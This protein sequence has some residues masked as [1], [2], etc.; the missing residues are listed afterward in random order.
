MVFHPDP[1]SAVSSTISATI[2]ILEVTYQLKAVGQQTADLLS[3]TRH[4]DFMLQQANRLR[5]LKAGL[6]NTSERTMVDTVISDTEDALRAVA[7]LV[8]HCR[9]D[10][11]TTN[12]IKFGHRVMW[13]FRD[14]PSVRDKHQKLQVCYQSLT[15]V[16]N[17]L[18]S[19]DVVVIAPIPEVRSEEQPP[20]YDPQLKELLEW[21][22][23]RKGR[24]SKEERESI[25]NENLEVTNGNANPT[26]VAGASSPC[27]LA[28]D[29]CDNSRTSSLSTYTDMFSESPATTIS[30]ARPS[31]LP[32]S[33]NPLSPATQSPDST[34]PSLHTSAHSSFYGD[35][36]QST[37]PS[38]HART[39]NDCFGSMHNLPKIDSPPFAA[40][41]APYQF[42][43][44]DKDGLQVGHK[45]PAHIPNPALDHAPT[46]PAVAFH[47]T[48]STTPAIPSLPHTAVATPTSS[49]L[50]ARD[51]LRSRW[52][53]L[54]ENDRYVAQ[55][56][57]EAP[58]VELY[59]LRA[60][61][62][63]DDIG[64]GTSYQSDRLD[65]I[66]RVEDVMSRGEKVTSTGQG[67][68]KRGGRSWL[69][70]HATRSDTGDGMDWNG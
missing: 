27:L 65:A 59:P 45:H 67:V 22:N 37:P 68:M 13:V 70:Y 57:T 49:E 64:P 8:E 28:I 31:V 20:P 5:R 1:L 62:K 58:E 16:F 41:I 35:E 42:T 30:D 36:N 25:R 4:V 66:A 23:R 40:M 32:D 44:D 61:I 39:H 26:H 51:A 12:G 33:G 3:T 53:D 50:S 52:L 54:S 14:N 9:V 6:L 21:Q 43:N 56:P 10:K 47:T 2:K 60:S 55:E 29:L 24:K 17:C 11:D 19:K 63:S 46:S 38:A 48:P 69:A 7:K 15:I 34:N 18:Y